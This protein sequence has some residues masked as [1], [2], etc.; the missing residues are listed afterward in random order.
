MKVFSGKIFPNGHSKSWLYEVYLCYRDFNCSPKEYQFDLE[1]TRHEQNAGKRNC[2]WFRDSDGRLIVAGLQLARGDVRIEITP[3]GFRNIV[4]LVRVFISYAREDSDAAS[5]L[6]SELRDLSFD[7]WFDLENLEPGTRWRIRIQEAIRAS[8]FVI[9]L[10]S[11]RST[12]K[13]G[14]V[15]KEIRLALEVLEDM[16]DSA[17]F[18][19]PARLDECM[20]G[21]HALRELHW[22]DLFPNWEAGLKKIEATLRRWPV[23]R[24][25]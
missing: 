16:P 14:F 21:H 3:S 6:Y 18:L 2:H 12:G 20:P 1:Y 11:T 15:Q 7:V 23:D 4:K 5:R 8:D 22:I 9:A 25:G 19:I 10:M 24:S 13:R 17:I